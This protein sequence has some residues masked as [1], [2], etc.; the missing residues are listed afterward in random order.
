VY[1]HSRAAVAAAWLDELRETEWVAVGR[2]ERVVPA[3]AVIKSV[4]TQTLY[5]E[6][7]VGLEAGDVGD[8][9]ATALHLI[10]DVRVADLVDYIAKVRDGQQRA[11]EAQ[12]HQIYR[13]IAKR[14]PATAAWNTPIGGLT[15][16]ELRRR[17]AQGDGLIFVGAGEWRRPN[18][19]RRGSDIFHDRQ[20]FVPGG[21]AL[22]DLWLVL[23]VR[24]P[25]LDDCLAFCKA[26][27]A[28]DYTIHTSA[29]LIDVYRYMEPLLPAAERKHRNRLK[30]LPVACDGHWTVERP[31]CFV[32]DDELRRALAT[33]L[34]RC[35]FW[36]P[37]CNIRDLPSLVSMIG[38]TI[39]NRS[40]ATGRAP[41]NAPTVIANALSE[42]SITSRMNSPAM[43][44]QPAI[45]SRSAGNA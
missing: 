18:Q 16:Q 5:R 37:P 1:T 32:E 10:T 31:S 44:P 28:Q 26:L 41:W 30:A 43:T 12:L 7:A 33:A 11:D 21:S 29:A 2:G 45:G 22:A 15:A 24:Q 34:P 42:R 39:A 19:V 25:S 13:T 20:R 27:A 38:V 36:S 4:E 14:C 35:R 40:Q 3:A 8:A 17:F 6:F 23:G 9:V